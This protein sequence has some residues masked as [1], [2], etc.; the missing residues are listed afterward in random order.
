MTELITSL[1][2]PRV[3]LAHQLQQK[4]RTRRKERKIA[5]EGTRLVLD[6]LQRGHVPL[7]AL[8]EASRVDY[9]LL[10]ALQTTKA[11]LL[12]VNS[13]VMQ[14]VSD[15]QNPQGIVAVYSIPHVPLPERLER[16]LVL[17]GI[18][19]P[20]NMGTLLRT[21]GAAGVQVVLL[22]SGCVDPYNPKVLRG[23]MGAHFRLPIVEGKW[24]EIQQYCEK[25][26]F[27]IAA[28]DGE[29]RYSD[30]DWT[31]PW[32]LVIGSEAHG[33]SQ[34]A[35]ALGTLVRIPMA[36]ATES[37]NAA[38]AAGVILFEAQRQQHAR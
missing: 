23:G 1:Q 29:K 20:G 13:A 21:A 17:D 27:F 11:P 38:V 25:L 16:A 3:K 14:H 24:Y 9:E 19:E 37:I 35:R 33:A 5:L 31:Q 34:P 15:T 18:G 2:N 4:A 30:V 32:A 10:A 36:S 6:A 7:F 8:Y 26:A 28:G 22:A 12:S